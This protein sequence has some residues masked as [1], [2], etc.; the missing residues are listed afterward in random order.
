M[1]MYKYVNI[2]HKINIKLGIVDL[3]AHLSRFVPRELMRS[4]E[5]RMEQ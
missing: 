4:D 2:K 1:C 3:F 5:C